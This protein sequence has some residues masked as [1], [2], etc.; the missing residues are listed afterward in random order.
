MAGA[1]RGGTWSQSQAGR[2]SGLRPRLQR[3]HVSTDALVGEVPRL[4]SRG[5]SVNLALGQDKVSM[6][7][8]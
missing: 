2:L 1:P 7:L 3:E 8:G 4:V 6:G 5:G